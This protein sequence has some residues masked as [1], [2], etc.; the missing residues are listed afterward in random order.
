M[1]IY[2]LDPIDPGHHSWKNSDEKDSVWASAETA[3]KARDLV[4]AKTRLGAE[5]DS[6]WLRVE[7]TSCVL[8][9]AMS[10]IEAG[11]VVRGDGSLVGG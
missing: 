3:E 6:P 9:P 5:N 1:S 8:E 10:H 4:A 2:R 7:A 11:T